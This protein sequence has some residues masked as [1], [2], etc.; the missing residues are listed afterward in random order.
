LFSL[1]VY[2]TCLQIG[3][4]IGIAIS[5]IIANNK[6]APT[7]LGSQLLP[8]YRAAFYTQ[9]AI[10]GVGFV[11]TII[12]HPNRDPAK[13]SEGATPEEV[14]AVA[15]GGGDENL[16][17]HHHNNDVAQ[18]DIET[19]ANS[20]MFEMKNGELASAGAT[21]IFQGSSTSLGEKTELK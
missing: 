15:A 17:S 12:F 9:A 8:G 16:S 3:A 20:E 11:V 5:N 14:A 1:S 10:A 13:L 19:A 6:N 21:T 4:P 7:A 18:K 2:N